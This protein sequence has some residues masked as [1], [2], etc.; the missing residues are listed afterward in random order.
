M[1]RGPALA[2][3]HFPTSAK[4]QI[5]PIRRNIGG[6]REVERTYADLTSKILTFNVY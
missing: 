1:T 4:V 5:F 2:V 6:R 3:G